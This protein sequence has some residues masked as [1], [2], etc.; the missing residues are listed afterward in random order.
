LTE[1][2]RHREDDWF[3]ENERK[4]LEEARLAREQ[5]EAERKGHEAKAERERLKAA[6]YMKCPKCGHDLK[7]SSSRASRST[8]ARSARASSSTPGELEQMFLTMEQ[9]KRQGIP[10]QP[11]PHL[12]APRLAREQSCPT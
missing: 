8:A 3:R 11:A 1:S 10:P 2:G 5:R 4:L 7:P 12:T 6:H 9:S